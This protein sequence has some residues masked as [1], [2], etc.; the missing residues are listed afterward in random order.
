MDPIVLLA[1][2]SSYSNCTLVKALGRFTMTH[3]NMQLSTAALASC[4][5]VPCMR[6]RHLIIRRV[7]EH[8]I[9]PTGLVRR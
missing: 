2:T 7:R 1:A 3:V 4:W 9:E 6:A 8:T 5:L